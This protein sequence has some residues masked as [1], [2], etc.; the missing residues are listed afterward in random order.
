MFWWQEE[1]WVDLG[2]EWLQ[3]ALDFSFKPVAFVLLPLRLVRLFYIHPV[4]LAMRLHVTT[5]GDTFLL[6]R[7]RLSWLVFVGSYLYDHFTLFTQILILTL[8]L[9]QCLRL[10]MEKYL[11]WMM[12]E[13]YVRL[14]VLYK[15]DA[16]LYLT[17]EHYLG[18]LG[19]W[20]LWAFFRQY[21]DAW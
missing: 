10:S 13:R 17:G 4:F 9:G 21:I 20:K 2:K 11:F 19:P 8:M 3:V 14:Y 15:T 6:A 16:L 7:M 5:K 12:V 1:W 18:G